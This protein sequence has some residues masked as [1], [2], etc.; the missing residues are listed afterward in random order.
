MNPNGK[1]KTSYR[2][3]QS[4]T[5]IDFELLEKKESMNGM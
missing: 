1:R 5:K 4:E 2:A 3:G